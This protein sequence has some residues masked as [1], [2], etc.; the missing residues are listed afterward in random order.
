MS[1]F[2][3][4]YNRRTGEV[5]VTEFPEG[6]N[7]AAMRHRLALERERTSPDVEIVSLV[8][9]SIDDVRRTHSRYFERELAGN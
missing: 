4:Q 8:S 9:E 1:S 7:R 2:V 3:V 6:E 5:E